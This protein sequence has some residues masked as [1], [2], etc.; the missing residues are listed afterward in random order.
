M[1]HQ[2]VAQLLSEQVVGG[3]GDGAEGDHDPVR[4]REVGRHGEE[5][6]GVGED[7][8]GVCE[9]AL[10]EEGDCDRDEGVFVYGDEAGEGGLEEGADRW[11][12][13]SDPFFGD[14][15][16]SPLLRWRGERFRDAWGR[17]WRG[18]I[19]QADDRVHGGE[20]RDIARDRAI[21]TACNGVVHPRTTGDA[22][23]C[24]F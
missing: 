13:L 20:G 6:G 16:D 5:G 2:E 17:E 18:R 12:C 21:D 7:G 15:E 10:G 23:M 19:R 1:L 11:C 3:R 4:G 14:A 24:W 22:A 8:E 9:L